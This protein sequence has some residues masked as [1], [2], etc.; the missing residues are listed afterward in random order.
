MV[1]MVMG[2]GNLPYIEVPAAFTDLY[3]NWVTKNKVLP[4]I[5]ETVGLDS[6][7]KDWPSTQ[8]ENICVPSVSN[9]GVIPLGLVYPAAMMLP[10]PAAG[11]LTKVSPVRYSS[12]NVNA[13]AVLTVA[14]L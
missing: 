5:P 8:S 4:V 9:I 10:P 6:L 13:C 11:G 14:S 1:V 2:Q 7:I 3:S 12:T